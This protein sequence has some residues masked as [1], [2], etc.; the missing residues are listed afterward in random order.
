MHSL[1]S[2]DRTI[3]YDTGL[4]L[5][6]PVQ[7]SHDDDELGLVILPHNGAPAL[8][9]PAVKKISTGKPHLNA[10][11]VSHQRWSMEVVT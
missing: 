5:M 10:Y 7:T 11:N 2:F 4:N 9:R 6:N 3:S 8:R 1:R